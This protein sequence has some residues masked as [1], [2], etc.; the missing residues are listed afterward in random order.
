MRTTPPSDTESA[1]W[2]R[3]LQTMKDKL[4]PESASALLLL[5]F[6]PEDK[7]RMHILAAK[8][9]DGS[10]TAAEQQEIRN[11]ETVGNVLGCMKSIARQRLKAAA[12][13]NGSSH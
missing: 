6:P 8:A 9:R 12:H 2:D 5:V 7:D 13:A 3:V 1:I 4:S 10:L 11:Y